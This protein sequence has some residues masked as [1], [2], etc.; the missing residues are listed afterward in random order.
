MHTGMTVVGSWEKHLRVQTKTYC[1][2]SG[3]M[4]KYRKAIESRA[5]GVPLKSGGFVQV[6]MNS[7]QY[8]FDIVTQF[9]IEVENDLTVLGV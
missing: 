2:W 1:H 4:W 3:M 9:L 5:T 6:T 7:L 8:M